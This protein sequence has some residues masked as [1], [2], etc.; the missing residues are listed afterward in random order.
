MEIT[1]IV[2]IESYL[3]GLMSPDERIEFEQKIKNDLT[4]QA[5]LKIMQ[6]ATQLIDIDIAKD[7]KLK[8]TQWNTTEKHSK[9]RSVRFLPYA[10]AASILICLCLSF[11]YMESRFSNNALFDKNFVIIDHSIR[12]ETVI[13]LNS[14]EAGIK[15]TKENPKQ[16]ILELEQVLKSNPDLDSKEKAEWYLALA[17]LKINNTTECNLYLQNIISQKSHPFRNKAIKLQED[18]SKIW[19]I[20]LN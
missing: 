8:L 10:A 12:G 3:S 13:E 18:I 16:A 17:N 9:S 15:N 6:Q 7:L 5:E 4:L 2:Q 20:R 11:L 14:F 1:N 19:R